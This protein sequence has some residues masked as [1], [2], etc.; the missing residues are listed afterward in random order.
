MRKI[1]LGSLSALLAGAGLAVA[2]PPAAL[3]T[4]RTI[5]VAEPGGGTYGTGTGTGTAASSGDAAPPAPAVG[6]DVPPPPPEG[7]CPPW[8]PSCGEPH[9]FWF[10]AEYLHWWMEENEFPP[11][12][13]AGPVSSGGVV[14]SPG[15]VALGDQIDERQ[16]SGGRFT[17]GGW[18]THYQGLGLE[19]SVFFLESS[20][21]DFGVAGTGGPNSPL[22]AR[23]FFNVLTG[24]ESAKII[25]APNLFSG[26][27]VGSTFGE[28]TGSSRLFG[29]EVHFLANLCCEFNYRIDLLL[30]Y[31]YLSLDDN[32]SI[33]EN[34]VAAATVPGIGG[35]AFSILDK[36]DTDNEF[37]GGQVG[38]RG[39]WNWGRVRAQAAAKL[40][41][42]ATEES[43]TIAG[44]TTLFPRTGGSAALPGGFY[45]VPSNSGLFKCEEFSVVPELGVNLG[46]RVCQSVT[47]FGGY[48]F[49]YWST[50]ARSG[51]QINRNINILE[52]PS[53][54]GTNIGTAQRSNAV[55]D[56]DFW[57]HGFSAGFELRY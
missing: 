49:L 36:F 18:A 32:L 35:T 34:S 25:S 11:L 29:A 17:L 16:Q 14:G 51:D 55:R 45:A 38:V 1:F 40:A 50:V 53:I 43:V 26:S 3:P 9:C 7:L 23:P 13:T 37:N 6:F 2:E 22:L 56:N 10:S 20:G 42:G 4:P 28:C 31:R 12:F 24:S 54:V 21:F 52:V 15:T 57:A 8:A 33:V 48:N 44:M 41:I 19:V 39:E 47:L 5:L 27:A 46:Y 30:G